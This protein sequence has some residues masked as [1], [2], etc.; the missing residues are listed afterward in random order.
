MRNEWY[1]DATAP[2]DIY[3]I[4]HGK[5]SYKEGNEKWC[6]ATARFDG[7]AWDTLT[8]QTLNSERIFRVAQETAR[9][10]FRMMGM[11]L[12]P[13]KPCDIP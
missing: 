1:E 4:T 3:R 11:R 2:G 6:V 7:K 10:E 13:K 12:L 5:I 9:E 8:R